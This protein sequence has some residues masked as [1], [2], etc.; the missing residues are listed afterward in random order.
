MKKIIRLITFVFLLAIF[1]PTAVTSPASASNCQYSAV[2]ATD[3]SG[4]LYKYAVDGTP[5]GSPV[6]LTTVYF[7]IA[8]DSNSGTFYGVTSNGTLDVVNISTGQVIRSVSAQS[9]FYNSLSVLPTGMVA[10]SNGSMIVYIDPR[11]GTTTDYFDMN[12]IV[13]ENN[14]T[15]S[16][17]SAAGDFITMPDGSLLALLSNSNVGSGTVA[18]K[19]SNGQGSILGLVPAAWGGARVGADLFLGGA[20]GQLRK[21]SSLPTV[22]GRGSI[23]TTT[24]ASL[25]SGGYYGAAGTEDSSLSSCSTISQNGITPGADAFSAASPST[26][27]VAGALATATPT[28]AAS[29][30]PS[31]TTSSSSTPSASSS[32]SAKLAATGV[33]GNLLEL[34]QVSA[35]VAVGILISRF[36]RKRA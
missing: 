20:D 13:D 3:G 14:Q 8:L 16:G 25:Q 15:Y 2:Y 24:I 21:I 7:D 36:A 23:A 5:I 9:G 22:A 4:N 11:N 35:L 29:Q 26:P 17:W 6:T 33:S 18:V 28:Q 34:L 31:A 12:L 32:N 10:A 27:A 19:I 1:I 30:S